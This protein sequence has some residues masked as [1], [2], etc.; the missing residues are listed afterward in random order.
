MAA[1][2]SFLAYRN[3]GRAY[4]KVLRLYVV[5]CDVCIVAK[6]YV[7]EQNVRCAFLLRSTLTPILGIHPIRC[8]GVHEVPESHSLGPWPYCGLRIK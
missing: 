7:L 6:R 8:L 3:N 2:R 1:R 4:A 5:V